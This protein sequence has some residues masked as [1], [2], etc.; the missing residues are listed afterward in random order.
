[1]VISNKE[2]WIH[3]CEP[4][5]WQVKVLRMYGL[6]DIPSICLSIRTIFLSVFMGR[7]SRYIPFLLNNYCNST[8]KPALYLPPLNYPRTETPTG[9]HQGYDFFSEH[10]TAWGVSQTKIV[11][12]KLVGLYLRWTFNIGQ[13]I[14]SYTQLRNTGRSYF[15]NSPCDL[16]SLDSPRWSYRHP[17]G[18]ISLQ[19]GFDAGM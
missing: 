13:Q 5:Y 17:L 7:C 3:F 9:D 2:V 12:Q 8:S 19:C 15:L 18:F 4:A 1:M 16:Y 10:W 14:S 6:V 11:L